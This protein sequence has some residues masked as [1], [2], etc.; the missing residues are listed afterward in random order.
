MRARRSTVTF[1]LTGARMRL[2][3]GSLTSVSAE[4]LVS[5]D[6]VGL[7]ASG[8]VSKDLRLAAG[9]GYEEELRLAR[10]DLSTRGATIG[11]VVVTGAGRLQ[12]R[13]VLHVVTVHGL[14]RLEEGT[15][16]AALGRCLAL[17][18]ERSLRTIAFP[19]LGTGSAGFA[20]REAARILVRAMA[21]YFR[22]GSSTLTEVCF[23]IPDAGAFTAFDAEFTRLRLATS[24]EGSAAARQT[25]PLA[26]LFSDIVGS[27]AFFDRMGDEKG[28]EL[29]DRHHRLLV[30]ILS[31]HRGELIKSMGDGLLVVFTEVER[32][33]ACAQAMMRALGEYN[34]TAVPD[35]RLGL[36]L[37]IHHG[38]VV[39]TAGDVFGDVV[40]SAQRI[41]SMADPGQIVI[42]QTARALLAE[43]TDVRFL[44]ERKAKGKSDAVSVYELVW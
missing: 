10:A 6:D 32:A 7:S 29:L 25:L 38:D 3:P 24:F 12:A 2:H 43:S 13:H 40:N 22:A 14:L 31:A 11:D 17:A 37:G 1:E 20:P 5:S 33:A 9:A 27:T 35:W 19:A 28:M 16:A 18:S 39:A 8:G 36:R 23:A 21:T 42:S 44:G 41:Q 26:I 4:A 15:L 30:P 34:R